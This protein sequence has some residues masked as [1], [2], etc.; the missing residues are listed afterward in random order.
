MGRLSNLGSVV[1]RLSNLASA[2]GRLSNLGSVVGAAEQPR[3]GWGG[4]GRAGAETHAHASF[5]MAT[6]IPTNTKT[7]IASCIQNHMGDMGSQPTV[8]RRGVA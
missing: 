6:T 8:R 5:V 7:T 4:G 1:G 2:G 3:L